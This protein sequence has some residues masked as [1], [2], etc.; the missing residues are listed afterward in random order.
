MLSIDDFQSVKLEDKK[1]FDKHY[2]EYPPIHSDNVFST[3]ISWKEYIKYFYFYTK[4][5]LIIITKMGNIYR[6]RPPIGKRNKDLFEEVLK[7]AKKE[8]PDEPFGIIDKDTKDWLSEKF[9]K[10]KFIPQRDYF[11]YVYLSKNLAELPGKDYSKIRNRLNKFTR[12]HKFSVE[13]VSI[14]NI[15]EIKKFLKR[16][17]LWRDCDS[18]LLLENEKKAILFSIANFFELN[19]RGLVIRIDDRI[20]AISVFEPMSTNTA[21]VHYEKGSPYFDG[22]YKAINQETA[23]LLQ[24]NFKFINRE[25]DMGLSG[26]RKAKMSY[27]PHHMIEVYNVNK[28]DII[29]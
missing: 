29:L 11:D 2:K 20:E 1:I 8:G 25:P 9:A 23:K 17:C 22:I 6:F 19:L 4:S 18:D 24:D 7:L 12:N 5:N 10:L 14:E 3:I 15:N 27:R 28:K 13:C 26:L 21:V 16:W